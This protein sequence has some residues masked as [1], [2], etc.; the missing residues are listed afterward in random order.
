MQGLSIPQFAPLALDLSGI[1][2]DSSLHIGCEGTLLEA[3][4]SLDPA[5][6]PLGD[7]ARVGGMLEVPGKLLVLFEVGTGR[8]GK[9]V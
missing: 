6:G 3:G 9:C 8:Q 4:E 1:G 2:G 7:D 5:R